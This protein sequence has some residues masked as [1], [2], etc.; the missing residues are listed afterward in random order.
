MESLDKLRTRKG[1][2]R[3]SKDFSYSWHNFLLQTFHLQRVA[4]SVNNCWSSPCQTPLVQSMSNRNLLNL[5]LDLLENSLLLQE[6][7]HSLIFVS[8]LLQPSTFSNGGAM[9][10]QTTSF[11]EFVDRDRH[12]ASGK[13]DAMNKCSNLVVIVSNDQIYITPMSANN[14]GN[15]LE[16]EKH[17]WQLR[18]RISTCS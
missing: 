16:L 14:P 9:N 8:M 7:P 13:W 18:L 1:C 4:K 6:T 10:R 2:K 3:C 17:L 15:N 11:N 5:L 12:S